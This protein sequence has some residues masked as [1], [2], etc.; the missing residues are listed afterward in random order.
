M[1]RYPHLISRC[2]VNVP[3]NRLKD[4]YLDFMLTHR[5]QPEI[6][7]E[8]DFFYTTASDDYGAVA[9]VLQRAGLACTVHAPFFDLSPGAFDREV[10][11][12]TREKLQR[13]FD[14]IALF[15]PAAIVCHLNYEENKHAGRLD[16]WFANSLATWRELLAIA[17]KQQTPIMLEN[18][19]EQSPEQH[20]RL[21]QAL[22]SPCLRF[23][24]DTGHTLAFARN[25][26]RDWL[27]TLTPW[28]G[29]LH[30]HDNQGNSDEHQPVGSG[31]FDFAGLFGYLEEAR[32]NPLV[33]LEVR[34]E[35]GLW[36]SFEAL[37][38]L[39]FK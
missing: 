29:Q 16:E 28:L 14:L 32:L 23:C 21:F 10:R 31:L 1:S 11:R 30:L 27:P 3:F 6:G 5:L 36:Q 9:Q 17:E 38:R 24:L 18:T 39:N 4:E 25:S 22:P 8:G 37:E 20:Q 7:L 19:Y 35:K 33:T 12:V 34:D 26:W 2:F 13:A 15:N